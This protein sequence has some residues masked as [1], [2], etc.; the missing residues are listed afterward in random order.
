MTLFSF[1]LL[2]YDLLIENESFLSSEPRKVTD[3]NPM[4]GVG[5]STYPL[6]KELIMR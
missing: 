4:E 1:Y 2:G 3:T 6:L 5:G